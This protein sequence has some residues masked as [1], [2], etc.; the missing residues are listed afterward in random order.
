MTKDERW[1]A[2]WQDTIVFLEIYHGK[3]SKFIPEEHN[4]RAWWTHNKKLM[5]TGEM[6][7]IEDYYNAISLHL[8]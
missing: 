2:K 5:N 7:K 1:L 8:A 3:L 4:M 6:K